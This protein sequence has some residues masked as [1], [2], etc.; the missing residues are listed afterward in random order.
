MDQPLRRGESRSVRDGLFLAA[1]NDET[2]LVAGFEPLGRA[3][4]GAAMAGRAG[5]GAS[6]PSVS[7]R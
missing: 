2:D 7:E 6:S 1:D 3:I 5:T 4:W